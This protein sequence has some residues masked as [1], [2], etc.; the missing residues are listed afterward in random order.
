MKDDCEECQ[1]V[2]ESE[3]QKARTHL[4]NLAA[5][6]YKDIDLVTIA[7]VKTKNGKLGIRGPG[8]STAQF[9]EVEY[10]SLLQGVAVGSIH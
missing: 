8:E 7:I 6:K 2:K 9:E 4:L 5:A 3:R 10:I 1:K